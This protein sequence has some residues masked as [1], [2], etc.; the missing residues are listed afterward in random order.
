MI[1]FEVEPCTIVKIYC[2]WWVYRR[3]MQTVGTDKN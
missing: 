1:Y 3:C 2:A